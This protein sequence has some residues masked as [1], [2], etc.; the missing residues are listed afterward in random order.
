[1]TIKTILVIPDFTTQDRAAFNAARQQ[2][3]RQMPVW[4]GEVNQTQEEI[5]QSAAA[6]DQSV[7]DAQAWAGVA[8]QHSEDAGQQALD[9]A[10]S[11]QLA[12]QVADGIA[13][14]W[15]P[16]KAWPVNI[17]VWA[18]GTGGDRFRCIVPHAGSSTPPV[19]DPVHWV[20]VGPGSAAPS[21]TAGP[22]NVTLNRDAGGV[23]TGS[24]FVQDGKNGT[25]VL[26]R[27]AQGRIATRKVV[28]G[29]KTRLET[30]NR[31]P[32]TGRITSIDATEV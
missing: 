19:N 20:L 21:P 17:V 14:T 8:Q 3:A 22:S 25:E 23:L 5:N 7:I 30:I 16:N 28:F 2:L 32:A 10:T 13:V 15:E 31:D 4:T 11:A 18:S 6:A 27:D 26:T 9:A 24:T 1:M 12:A 29:G